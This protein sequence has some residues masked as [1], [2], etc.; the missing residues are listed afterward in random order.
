[1]SVFFFT[2]ELEIVYLKIASK[3]GNMDSLCF[4]RNSSTLKIRSHPFLLQICLPF[5]TLKVY[6]RSH[7]AQM[8]SLCVLV[9][10]RTGN[11]LWPS[12]PRT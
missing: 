1:M 2:M 11:W 9:P 5:T 4:T 3:R 8:P 6:I 7:I 10:S 12:K